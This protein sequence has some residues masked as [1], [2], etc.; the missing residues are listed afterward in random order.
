MA[1]FSIICKFLIF[2]AYFPNVENIYKYKKWIYL[3]TWIKGTWIY[4][5]MKGLKSLNF[6][7]FSYNVYAYIYINMFTILYMQTYNH[8]NL[9]NFF[10][11]LLLLYMHV[12]W[13][14]TN[15]YLETFSNIIKTRTIIM[16]NYGF[17]NNKK[18]NSCY[19]I[20]FLNLRL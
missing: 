17:E 10:L 1:N 15:I 6:I 14:Y 7:L 12:I 4:R 11:L 2:L 19:K 9:S 16:Q 20:I 3:M 13:T 18:K 5:E 8:F